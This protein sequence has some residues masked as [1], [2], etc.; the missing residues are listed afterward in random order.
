MQNELTSDEDKDI[1]REHDVSFGP[2]L[3]KSERE[4]VPVTEPAAKQKKASR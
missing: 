3:K 1:L 4:A 2:P